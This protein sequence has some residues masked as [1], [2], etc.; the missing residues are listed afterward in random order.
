MSNLP[1]RINICKAQGSSKSKAPQILFSTSGKVGAPMSL[2]TKSY[3]SEKINP[4]NYSE[5]GSDKYIDLP[6]LYSAE[7][8]P[9]Q[10]EQ[11]DSALAKNAS[12]KLAVRTA[13]DKCT[14]QAI[15]PV[16]GANGAPQYILSVE[17]VDKVVV[18]QVSNPHYN[19]VAFQQVEDL[20]LLLPLLIKTE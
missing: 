5:L 9:E 11:V 10:R 8:S 1:L 15:R 18:S 17:A 7:Y 3:R 12:V 13:Y 20:L 19:P 14:L 16:C 2:S 4:S 6:Q